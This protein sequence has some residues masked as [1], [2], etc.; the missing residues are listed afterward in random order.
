MFCVTL[1]HRDLCCIPF[2]PYFIFVSVF[3][4]ITN[5]RGAHSLLEAWHCLVFAFSSLHV[6]LF[7][8]SN[9]TARLSFNNLP[10]HFTTILKPTSL[11]TTSPT[12]LSTSL[13]QLSPLSFFTPSLHPTSVPLSF[14]PPLY[15]TALTLHLI[16]YPN[17]SPQ[18]LCSTY[19][20]TYSTS[21]RYT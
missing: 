6:S 16:F 5:L 21:L 7:I 11:P 3:A 17:P 18:P 8:L 4:F 2:C 1:T 14:T 12:P 10:Y 20:S 9:L 19:R 13:P 15:P